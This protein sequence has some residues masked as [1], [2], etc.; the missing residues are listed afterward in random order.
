MKKI[1]ANILLVLLVPIAT[2][3]QEIKIL[4]PSAKPVTQAVLIIKPLDGSKESIFLSNNSGLVEVG[5]HLKKVQI[6]ISHVSYLTYVD[7]LETLSNDLT[8]TLTE[9]D[10][11]LNEVVVSSEYTARTS[12]ESVHPVTVITK[13]QIENQ[14][15]TTLEEALSQQ[16]NVRTS[17]DQILGSGLTMNGLSGQNIKFL[18]DG[19]PMIGRLD[20]NIDLN[21]VLLND[22]ER[23]EIVNGPMA[24]SYGTDAA[25]GVIN[26]ITRQPSDKSLQGGVNLLYENVGQ[27][28]G[29]F[30]I[31]TGSGKSS[32]L[33]SGG[34]NFFNGWSP[35]DTGRWQ[36]WK[37]KEQFFGNFKYR[38]SGKKFVLGYQLNAFH[39][40]ISNKGT[41]KVSPYF[42]YAFDEY[43]TTKRLTNQLNGSYM[44]GRDKFANVI[45]SHSWYNRTKNTYRKDLVTLDE[46]LV[47]GQ[48]S[49]DSLTLSPGNILSNQDTTTMNSWMARGTFTKSE[50]NAVLNYQAGFDFNMDYADGTRFNQ[51]TKYTGDYAVFASAEYLLSPKWEIKPAIRLSYNTDYKAPVVPS[52]MVK[53]SPTEHMQIRF[54]YGKGFR[55]PGIKERYL[56]FVDI[57]HNIQGNE[58]LL[59]EYSDNFYLSVN[60]QSKWNKF[61]NNVA[62]SGFYNDIR[63]LITLAQPDQ[64]ESLFTYINLGK[65]STHGAGVTNTISYN[66]WSLSLGAAYTGRYNIYAD[67]G[68]FDKYL[69]SPDFNGSLQYAFQKIN[70]TTS[71]YFKYNGALPGYQVNSD[72]SISQFSNDSYKFLDATIRKGFFRNSFYVTA[73]VKNILDVTTINSFAQGSAHSSGS[74][75]QAI[76]T[77]RTFFMKLQYQFGR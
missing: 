68:A 17:Q 5:A 27:Y 32:V 23:I 12:G 46:L 59:P 15:I 22:V 35:T 39:E 50:N 56:Y 57:N 64:T 71:V 52:V 65:F 60:H 9:K 31:G 34:R 61:T 11:K 69:Y 43:Y 66:A 16:L 75:E 44:L 28:N 18:V 24:T 7:T 45:V 13:D 73:G 26:L 3:A 62:F 48:P 38:Y 10:V 6:V 8:I 29:D 76:G 77:G 30:S 20:G 58:N 4:S 49:S 42:A 1:I 53:Y 40:K 37:P 70:L 36:E 14:G 55:A 47:I 72:N 63:N 33:L 21:Q 25:G 74:D 19:V 41:P 51:S 54:S 67:S 2:F